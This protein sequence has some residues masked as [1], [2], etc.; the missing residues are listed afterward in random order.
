MAKNKIDSDFKNQMQPYLDI[1]VQKLLNEFESR[2]IIVPKNEQESLK[3]DKLKK[4]EG[5]I[6]ATQHYI[7]NDLFEFANNLQ[8]LYNL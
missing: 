7:F 6:E 8:L 1:Y 2:E 5:I 4:D 3:T